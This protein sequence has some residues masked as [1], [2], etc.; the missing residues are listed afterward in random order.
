MKKKLNFKKIIVLIFI[1]LLGITLV[2]FITKFKSQSKKQKDQSQVSIQPKIEIKQQYKGKPTIT[3]SFKKDSFNFPRKLPLLEI[4]KETKLDENLIK[5]IA[6]KLG[7]V[8][9]FTVIDDPIDGKTYF[10]SNEENVLFVY[11]KS[12]TIRY[13][14]KKKESYINKQLSGNDIL[15]LAQNFITKNNILEKDSFQLDNVTF[16][17]KTQ[18]NKEYEGGYQKTIKEEADLYQVD[19]L[20]KDIHYKIIKT[21]ST[22]TTSYIQ[23]TPD[24]SVY[25]FQITLINLKKGITEYKIKN[26]E[27]FESKINESK[28]IELKGGFYLLSELEESFIQNINIENVEIAYLMDF[29]KN[30]Y[31]IPV[32]KLSGK[33]T[34]K[35]S[36]QEAIATLYLPAFSEKP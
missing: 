26:Y 9:N 6:K 11:S 28:I 2:W 31:L 35:A 23:M 32:F 1:I 30:N 34:I 18:K 13:S 17:K 24:G 33:A 27:E 8:T 19:I 3:L 22:E 4:E 7:F 12:K 25:S 29:P 15:A 36:E 21:N 20:P 16:L 14:S 5:E 10:W